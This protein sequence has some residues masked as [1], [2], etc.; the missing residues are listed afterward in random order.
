MLWD[1]VHN[2]ECVNVP[3]CSAALVQGLTFDGSNF[4][5]IT[6]AFPSRPQSTQ[7]PVTPDER[8]FQYRNRRFSAL[9]LH[10]VTPALRAEG[11]EDSKAMK[12]GGEQHAAWLKR[13]PE[14]A[15]ALWDWLRAQ[16]TDDLLSSC[17][18][19]AYPAPSSRNAARASDRLASTVA[20]DMAQWWQ[21]TVAGYLGR[22]PKLLILARC[23]RRQGQSGG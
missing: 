4:S 9:A 13:L 1:G 17:L 20:L 3:S 11:I 5:C 19:T 21:P 8:D 16:S 10:V 22:V 6:H 2:V 18:L 7:E 14:D 12:H 23:H 15:A